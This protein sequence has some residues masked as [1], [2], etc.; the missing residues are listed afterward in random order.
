VS[1]LLVFFGEPEISNLRFSNPKVRA[2]RNTENLKS[3]I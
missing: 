1:S 3:E 2:S